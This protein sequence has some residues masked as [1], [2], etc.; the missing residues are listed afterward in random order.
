MAG[1][2]I[3]LPLT[4]TQVSCPVHT[5]V[6]GYTK[7]FWKNL[8]TEIIFMHHTSLFFNSFGQ[9]FLK[10]QTLVHLSIKLSHSH[11]SSANS[12][13]FH[14]VFM[15]G[16]NLKKY[17]FVCNTNILVDVPNKK[18]FFFLVLKNG[19]SLAR[20]ARILTISSGPQAKILQE[21]LPKTLISL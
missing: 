15:F 17:Q 20:L 16:R 6:I 1:T 10:S 14:W 5:M 4:R 21:F 19:V 12:T 11:K 13:L 8:N 18:P 9:T 3:N 2:A 7:V